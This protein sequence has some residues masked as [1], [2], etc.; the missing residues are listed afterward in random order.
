MNKVNFHF[1]LFH[2]WRNLDL[3]KASVKYVTFNTCLGSMSSCVYFFPF[4]SSRYLKALSLTAQ[5]S[6]W[7]GNTTT[8][9]TLSIPIFME[10]VANRDEETPFPF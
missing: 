2:I 8:R 5:Y 9:V 10:W 1:I 4:E 3:P 7:L 6:L